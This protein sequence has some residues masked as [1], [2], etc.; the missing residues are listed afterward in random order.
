MSNLKQRVN[1]FFNKKGVIVCRDLHK[2]YDTLTIG[3][4]SNK[5]SIT[6]LVLKTTCETGT[7]PG[8]FIKIVITNGI[9]L[10]LNELRCEWGK[11]WKDFMM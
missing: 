8:E 6:K 3:P 7:L 1:R 11:P 2:L 9:V 4:E 5:F 10:E